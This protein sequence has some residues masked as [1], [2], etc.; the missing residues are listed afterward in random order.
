MYNRTNSG[1]AGDER[2]VEKTIL[3][4][5]GKGGVGVSTVA[6][7]LALAFARAQKTVLLVDLC[8]GNPA[9]DLLFGLAERVVY[10]ASDLFSAR[11]DPRRGILQVPDVPYLSILP[12]TVLFSR[13]PDANEYNRFLAIVREATTASVLIIDAPGETAGVITEFVDV[14]LAV[15]DL[16]PASLRATAN[17]NRVDGSDVRLVLNRYPVTPR[18]GEPRPT[19]REALDLSGT[20]LGAILFDEPKLA[21]DEANNRGATESRPML[22]IPC[23]NLSVRLF[24]GHAPLLSGMFSKGRRNKMIKAMSLRHEGVF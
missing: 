19:V 11:V 15:S 18:S 3:V 10:D 9:Q 2:M 4:T 1:D 6:A 5:S 12:G 7:R 16:S 13:L 23:R 17:L 8:S 21:S 20:P 22:D 24:D 14:T